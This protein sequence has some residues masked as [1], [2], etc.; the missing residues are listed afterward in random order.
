MIINPAASEACAAFMKTRGGNN[1]VKIIKLTTSGIITA[2]P[3]LK[4][5]YD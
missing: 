1:A 5:I 3:S 2:A 4:F